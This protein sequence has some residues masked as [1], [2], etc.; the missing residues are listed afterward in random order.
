MKIVKNTTADQNPWGRF[1]PGQ[2]DQ[3]YETADK[4][5]YK[6]LIKKYI[7]KLKCISEA[8]LRQTKKKRNYNG[9][10]TMRCRIKSINNAA[11]SEGSLE[12]Q[13]NVVV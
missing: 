3:C 2:S 8:C 13:S 1:D 4:Y 11:P 10:V 6:I 7:I 9:S 5:D 12:K